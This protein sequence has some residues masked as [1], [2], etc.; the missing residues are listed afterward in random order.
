MLTLRA[1]RRGQARGERPREN[2]GKIRRINYCFFG[3]SRLFKPRFCEDIRGGLADLLVSFR[4]P[5]TNIPPIS[6][7]FSVLFVPSPRNYGI[8]LV[9]FIFQQNQPWNHAQI[10]NLAISYKFVKSRALYDQIWLTWWQI[11][12]S[13]FVVAAQQTITMIWDNHGSSFRSTKNGTPR[14]PRIGRGE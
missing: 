8:Q 2:Q 5:G 10:V 1:L 12:F 4:A 3:C 6:S 14:I 9:P 7:N 13:L 11:K